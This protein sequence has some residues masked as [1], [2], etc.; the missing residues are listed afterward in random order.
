MKKSLLL[1]VIAVLGLANVNAQNVEFGA[2]AGLNFASIYGDNTSDIGF[3]TAYNFGL[4]SEISISE[5]FSFQPELL[6]SGIG[7]SIDDESDDDTVAL[8]YLTVPLLGK[9]YL[10]ERFSVEAGPQVGFL[11]SA[12]QESTD[13]K[14]AF[15]TL[16]FG[17]SLGLGYKLDSGLNFSARYTL[18]LSDISESEDFSNNTGV[19]QLSIGYFFF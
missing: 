2:K 4:M 15:K 9:Y 10:T 18:G 6:Y 14:D 1:T 12:K 5:K 11:L 7:Y 3:V 16:D 8:N 17:T 13:V 19:L